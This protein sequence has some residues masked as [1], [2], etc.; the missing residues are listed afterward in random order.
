MI[1][2]PAEEEK[3]ISIEKLSALLGE[4][5]ERLANELEKLLEN[6]G[7]GEII[8]RIHD[9]QIQVIQVKCSFKD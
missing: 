9:H 2:Q 4:K 8:I 6:P 7:Y 5:I 1:F 3:N